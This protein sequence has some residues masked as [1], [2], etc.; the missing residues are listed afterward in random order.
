LRGNTAALPVFQPSAHVGSACCAVG[1]TTVTICFCMW[2]LYLHGQLQ[3][4]G[5]DHSVWRG[6]LSCRIVSKGV[7]G[8]KPVDI[9][10][11]PWCWCQ[12]WQVGHGLTT[13]NEV[14]MGLGEWLT[15]RAVLA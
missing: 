13:L 11:V 14:V 5:A 2:G 6:G 10:A 7:A 1:S 9:L 3:Q 8:M 4:A 15:T 12:G